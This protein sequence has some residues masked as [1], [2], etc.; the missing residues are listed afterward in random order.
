MHRP[1]INIPPNVH[2]GAPS[3]LVE[4]LARFDAVVEVGVGER[5]EIAAALADRGVDVTATDVRERSVPEAVAF[6]RDDVTDPDPAVYVDA[7]VLF[8]R[9]CPPELHRPLRDLA[10][11]H[12]AAFWFTTLGGD[13]PAVP[14]ERETLPQGETLF[15]ARERGPDRDGPR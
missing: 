11:T 13:W 12:D 15:V 9:N 8:S 14:V 5:P 6:V 4:R 3:A 10:R 7:D 2:E 1:L